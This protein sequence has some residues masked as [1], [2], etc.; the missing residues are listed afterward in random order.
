MHDLQ[1]R[2]ACYIDVDMPPVAGDPFALARDTC[3][4]AV[5]VAGD[6]SVDHE[7]LHELVGRL[8]PEVVGTVTHGSMGENSDTL[9]GEFADAHD[10]ANFA[11]WYALLQFGHGFRYDLHRVCGRGASKTITLGVRAL[12]T[13]G[14]LSAKRLR[15]ITLDEVR[16][17]FQ[18]PADEVL[19]EFAW[20]LLLVLRQAAER[21]SDLHMAD[22]FDFCGEVLAQPAAVQRPAATL[23]AALA[24]HFPAFNDQGVLADGHRVVFLKKATLAAGELQRLAARHDPRFALAADLKSAVAPMDNVVPAVLHYHGVLRLSPRLHDLIHRDRLPLARGPME[25][26]LRAVSL[27]VCEDLAIAADY[28]Y[29]PLDLGYYLW[30]HGKDAGLRQFAR[31]HTRNTVYY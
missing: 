17:H 6:V 21:L 23:V 13:D 25:A 28:R 10:A 3:R 27:A 30:L 4:R 29:T 1:E 18:L 7:A 11:V 14:A 31:H 22:F 9:A 24:N 16:A 5:A 15:G 26:E 2:T 8:A 19:D 12:R 20:Q